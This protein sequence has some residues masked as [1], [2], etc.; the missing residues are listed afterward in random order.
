MRNIISNWRIAVMCLLG[1]IAL[2]CI[3]S[4]PTNENTWF[5]DFLIAKSIG[6]ASAYILYRTAR[7]WEIKHLLPELDF[8][9]EV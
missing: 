1:T 4:E 3:V 2:I 8:L 9:K 5:R 6:T 7:Y